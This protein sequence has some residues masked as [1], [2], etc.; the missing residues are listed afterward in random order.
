MRR[1]F[2][3][4]IALVVCFILAASIFSWQ[5]PIATHRS[6]RNTNRFIP[7]K[8][9]VLD[10]QTGLMW[11][12]HDNGDGVTWQEAKKYCDRYHGGGFGDWRMPTQTELAS[13]YDESE[14]GYRPE[15]AVYDWQIY[16]TH[17]I[18][19]TGCAVWAAETHGREASCFLFDYGRKSL[20]D[21]SVC[22]ILRALPVRSSR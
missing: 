20:I 13:L 9:I 1:Y 19:L 11:A 2:R 7:Y 6:Q 16:I 4:S 14:P 17:S 22:I 21:R 3:W 8:G 5:K 18:H 10:T 12:A 15:C